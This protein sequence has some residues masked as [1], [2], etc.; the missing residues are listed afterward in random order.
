MP[1]TYCQTAPSGEHCDAVSLSSIPSMP[2]F[3]CA[4]C[5]RGLVV[6]TKSKSNWIFPFDMFN[7]DRQFQHKTFF[8]F[9][10]SSNPALKK[11]KKTMAMRGVDFKWCVPLL[12]SLYFLPNSFPL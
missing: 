8:L 2:G 7:F 6:L 4:D 11:S 12:S 9:F 3:D 5:G 1:P 10:S